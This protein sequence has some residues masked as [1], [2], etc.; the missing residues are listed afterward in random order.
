MS[1]S[2]AARQPA[3]MGAP[4]L[5]DYRAGRLGG[6]AAS[7]NHELRAAEGDAQIVEVLV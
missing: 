5:G 2:A 3:P 7:E 6:T 1:Y 4:A